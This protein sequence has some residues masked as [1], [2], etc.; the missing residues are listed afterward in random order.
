VVVVFVAVTGVV[1]LDCG[2]E[3]PVEGELGVEIDGLVFDPFISFCTYKNPA[4]T[5]KSTII[6]RAA[7]DRLEAFTTITIH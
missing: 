7:T 3:D 5:A 4:N 6:V 2:D 1:E